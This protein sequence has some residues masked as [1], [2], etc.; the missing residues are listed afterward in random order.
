LLYFDIFE[1]PLTHKE[2]KGFLDKEI[3][4]ED[5]KFTLEKPDTSRV[6]LAA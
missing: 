4:D 2:I 3:N 1:Y 5:L 6:Y